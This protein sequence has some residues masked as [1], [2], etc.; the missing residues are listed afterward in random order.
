MFVLSQV[1]QARRRR[2]AIQEKNRE[3]A[4]KTCELKPRFEEVKSDLRQRSLQV[5]E[6]REAYVSKFEELSKKD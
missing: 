6:L 3:L 5:D 1:K 4:V 2:Q